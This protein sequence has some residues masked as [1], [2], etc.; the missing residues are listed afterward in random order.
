VLNLGYDV[1][2][3]GGAAYADSVWKGFQSW[4]DA[5]NRVAGEMKID[6]F[7][8][9]TE[10]DYIED[11]P[12]FAGI[13]MAYDYGPSA[14]TSSLI[15]TYD[16]FTP[17]KGVVKIRGLPDYEPMNIVG[18]NPIV[19]HETGHQLMF[20]EH[21]TYSNHVMCPGGGAKNPSD[22]E[23]RIFIVMYNLENLTPMR[24]YTL[25]SKSTSMTN[26]PVFDMGN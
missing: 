3:G 19:S 2:E 1:F 9:F 22:F 18:A 21:S 17:K 24:P 6:S 7:D 23:A 14:A 10:V 26:I 16:D 5:V 15:E 12:S 11:V 20:I 13:F 8:I 25:P 4:E